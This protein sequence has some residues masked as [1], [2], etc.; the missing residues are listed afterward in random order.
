MINRQMPEDHS[1]DGCTI[2]QFLAKPC[3]RCGALHATYEEA[4]HCMVKS[5]A[6]YSQYIKAAT[7]KQ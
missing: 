2:C 3:A 6:A 5:S 7:R 4:A 1:P